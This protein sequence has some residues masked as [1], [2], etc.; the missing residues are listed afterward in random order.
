[1]ALST[2]SSSSSHCFEILA[3]PADGESLVRDGACWLTCENG[4]RYPVVEGVPVLLRSDICEPTIGLTQKSVE[5][6]AK[7][8]R[9]EGADGDPWFVET[10]G[11]SDEEKAALRS[12][13][14]EHGGAIAPVASFL[15]GATNG[16]LCKNAIGKLGR[17]PLPGLRL[18]AGEGKRFL[19]I[20][21]SWG[22]WSLAA[23]KKGYRPI[24]IDPSLG[25]VL[26]AKRLAKN[27]GLP[28][29][30][31]VADARY[32]PLQAGSVDTAFSYS[33]LQ[34]FSKADARRALA[35]IA[36]ATRFGG[37]VKIQMASAFGV[38]S[39]QH[40]VR[41]GFKT[42]ENFEVRY[43]TPWELRRRFLAAFGDAELEVDCYFGL[44]LQPSDMDICTSPARMV[45]R[46]SELLRRVAAQFR[47]IVYLADSLYLDCRNLSQPA[48]K[49][50]P[51]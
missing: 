21:C 40:I 49:E 44:G 38:R 29:D 46:L 7:Y 2:S 25:A 17:I 27:L 4:H 37:S 34:H 19:D 13:I 30:G 26:A 12:V 45:V 24:G 6:A 20:G 47:P 48:N 15:V 39:L 1:M 10:L 8:A 11:I 42:P 32:L 18:P 16:I 50:S 14:V 9:A 43:W 28:F 35:Q 36:N 23:A 22:R 31:I 51:A 5:A 33:V 41:R 3:C